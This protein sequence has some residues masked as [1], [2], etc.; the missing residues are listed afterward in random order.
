MDTTLII[1]GTGKTGR[2]VAE[3]LMALGR[4]V[5]IASR[6]GSPRFE[7]TDR[8][9]WP[10]AVR[11]VDSIYLAY[12]PD[13]AVPGAADDIGSLAKLAV[14]SG[15]RRIVLLSGRGELQVLPSEAAVRESGAAFTILRCAWFAQNFSEGLLLEPV[16]AG[17]IAFPAGRVAEPFIDAD[18]IA[19]VAVAA[20]TDAAHAGKTYELTGPRL[21]TFAEAAA[22]ISR[23]AERKVEYVPITSAAYASML[24]QFVPAEQVEFIT[25]LFEDVLDGHNAFL[26]DGVQRVLGRKPRDFRDFAQ[27]AARAGAWRRRAAG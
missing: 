22:E 20:L 23:A 18:D 5:R 3:R 26:T 9:T 13:L 21:L 2:R 4:P 27:A 15:V 17:E 12:H 19:D 24:A 25:E 7:W 14:E 8:S 16:L 11:G 1:S 10:A 6:S